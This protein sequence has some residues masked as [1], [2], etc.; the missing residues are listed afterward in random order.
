LSK[1]NFLT[2]DDCIGREKGGGAERNAH[3][4]VARQVLIFNHEN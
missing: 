2:F 4:W 3:S 1:H